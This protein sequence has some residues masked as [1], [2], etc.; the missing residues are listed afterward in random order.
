MGETCQ[1][2]EFVPPPHG[3]RCC[4]I[5]RGR[6]T[7]VYSSGYMLVNSTRNGVVSFARALQGL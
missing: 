2:F 4:E 6:N 7:T 3:D 5:P 1:M